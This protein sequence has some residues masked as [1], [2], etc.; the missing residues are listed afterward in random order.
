MNEEYF[1]T[2][3]NEIIDE[4]IEL[5]EENSIS[6]KLKLTNSNYVEGKYYTYLL[7]ARDMFGIDKYKELHNYRYEERKEAFDYFKELYGKV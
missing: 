7:V 6:L 5:K 4:A 3:L 1:K 2:K